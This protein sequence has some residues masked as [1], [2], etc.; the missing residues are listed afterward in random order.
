VSGSSAADV[1]GTIAFWVMYAVLVAGVAWWASSYR[2]SVFWWTILAI[3]FSPVVAGVFLLV[4]GVPAETGPPEPESVDFDGRATCE[5]CGAAVDWD[6]HE[7]LHSAEGEPWRL[8][9]DH[10]GHELEVAT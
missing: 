1:A 9:C 4:A 8:L 10:C 6:T 3:V 5:S 2:R 7:G